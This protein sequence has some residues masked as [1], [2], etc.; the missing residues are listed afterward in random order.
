MLHL[1]KY[2]LK[3]MLK[4]KSLLFWTLAFPIL[5]TTLFS[6]VLRG[7]FHTLPFSTLEVAVVENSYYQQDVMLQQTMDSVTLDDKPMFK[8]TLMDEAQAKQALSDK[9]VVAYIVDGEKVQLFVNESNIKTTIVTSFFEEYQQQMGMIQDLVSNGASPQQLQAVFENTKDY[10]SQNQVSKEIDA[11]FF[12]TV[13]AMNC[14]FGGYWTINATHDIQ[15]NQCTRA[16]RLAC[17]PMKKSMYLFVD[18]LLCML[19]EIIIVLLLF[20]YMYVLL[21]IDFGSYTPQIIFTLLVGTLAGNAAGT[22]IGVISTK[23]VNFK[24]GMLTAVTML[25][26]FLSGM[27]MVQMKYMVQL[28]LPWAAMINPV[29]MITDGLYSLYYFGI[30]ER[31]YVNLLSLVIFILIGYGASFYMLR[32]RQYQS[33]EAR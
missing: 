3:C 20:S 22:F 31:Y 23:N 28:Y 12:Y 25:C 16:A 26:S 9:E 30:G 29:N 10:V 17:T 33:L 8:I 6:L 32:K 24:T 2:R 7:V 18:F 11:V 27:M 14:L 4:N 21:G 5:L 1:C 15:A 13:L 19:F